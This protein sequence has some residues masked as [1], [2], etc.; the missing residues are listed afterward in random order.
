[1]NH[2]LFYLQTLMT[3][4]KPKKSQLKVKKKKYIYTSLIKTVKDKKD[5]KKTLLGEEDSGKSVDKEEERPIS[6]KPLR[7]SPSSDETDLV[8]TREGEIIISFVDSPP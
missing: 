7:E 5:K 3:L 6:T 1:M 8:E 4:H 2:S